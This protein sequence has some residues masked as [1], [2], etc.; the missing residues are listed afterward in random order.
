MGFS[1]NLTS[2]FLSFNFVLFISQIQYQFYELLSNRTISN[3]CLEWLEFRVPPTTWNKAAAIFYLC[4]IFFSE[5]DSSMGFHNKISASTRLQCGPFLPD[6]GIR[7]F[8]HKFADA[9]ERSSVL[10]FESGKINK[11]LCVNIGY[12]V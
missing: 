4:F 3:W 5:N 2:S 10:W 9:D 1:D 6:L 7:D 8:G 11:K 12:A